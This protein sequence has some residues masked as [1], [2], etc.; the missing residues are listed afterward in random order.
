MLN[1]LFGGKALK[2]LILSTAYVFLIADFNSCCGLLTLYKSQLAT[3]IYLLQ[4]SD[5]P[6]PMG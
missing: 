5:P 4:F 3:G 1:P 6:L 2:L